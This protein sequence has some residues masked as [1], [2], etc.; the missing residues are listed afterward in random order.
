MPKVWIPDNHSG[1]GEPA[2][3]NNGFD[4]ILTQLRL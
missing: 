3:P 1:V 2:A 4:D